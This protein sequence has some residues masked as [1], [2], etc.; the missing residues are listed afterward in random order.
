MPLYREMG[1]IA[2]TFLV[3]GNIVGIGIFTTSGLIA[4]RLGA[5]PWLIGIWI[6]GGLLALV[7]ALCY[8]KLGVL[9]PHA[10]GEYAFLRPTFGPMAAFLSGWSSL[11]IGFT[12]PIAAS[13]LGFAH[14]LASFLPAGAAD[15]GLTLRGIAALSLLLVSVLFSF[16][17]KAGNRLHSLITVANLA[18]VLLFAILVLYVVPWEKHLAPALSG[19]I[20]AADFPSLGSSVILVMFTYSGWNAAAYVAGEIRNPARNIPLAMITGTILVVVLYCLMNLAYLAGS[21]LP[22]ISNEVAV[23]EVTASNVFGEFG[24]NVVNTLILFSI[25]SSLTA[26][27]IAGPRVYYAMADDGL[28]PHWL[29]RVD[30]RRKIPLRAIWFQTLVAL[31]F[32]AVGSLYQILVYSG[33][34]LIL[35]STLTI[36]G[37]FKVSRSRFLPAAFIAVNIVVLGSAAVSDPGETL[38][39]L[40]TVALGLPV[41]AYYRRKQRA[42]EGSSELEAGSWKRE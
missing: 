7:G 29:T 2:S 18:L 40:G 16:G 14:Y 9:Y 15:D 1:P 32:V 19:R 20:G 37:L 11:F 35:F 27:A 28:F 31:C 33:F 41:Y 5:S 6:L 34:V 10:G 22:S 38:A 4:G 24:R 23:A 3:I 36:A 21:S 39:G 12:A 8:S 26:M 13:A 17:L 25:L 30:A 42:E